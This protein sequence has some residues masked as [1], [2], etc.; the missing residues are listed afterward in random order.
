MMLFIEIGHFEIRTSSYQ[1]LC[2]LVLINKTDW[3]AGIC[4]DREV[5]AGA[6]NH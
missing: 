2:A 5:G 1:K 4:G 3:D 6:S